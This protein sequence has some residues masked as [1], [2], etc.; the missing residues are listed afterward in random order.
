MLRTTSVKCV[1]FIVGS[2]LA[3]WPV[4]GRPTAVTAADAGTAMMMLLASEPRTKTL[5]TARRFS[6]VVFLS[7]IAITSAGRLDRQTRS[8]R[9][10]RPGC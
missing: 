9:H 10:P 5:T 1:G 7:L 4:G 2:P 8:P 3:S 6:T